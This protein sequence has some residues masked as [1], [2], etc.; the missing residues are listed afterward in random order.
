MTLASSALAIGSHVYSSDGDKLGTIKEVW[1]VYFKVDAAM[2][3]DYWL[4]TESVKSSL[5][6]GRVTVVFDKNHLDE[7]KRDIV[8]A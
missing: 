4:G 7:Y 3:P 5:E 8:K 6:P 2:H 1:D